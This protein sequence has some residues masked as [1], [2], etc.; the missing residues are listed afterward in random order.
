MSRGEASGEGLTSE[1]EAVGI[2]QGLKL[3]VSLMNWICS[4]LIST[5]G[6]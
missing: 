4:L 3:C 1:L 2:G 5:V 6:C